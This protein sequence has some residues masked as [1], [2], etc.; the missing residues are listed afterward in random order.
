[1]STVV[2]TRDTLNVREAPDGQAAVIGTRCALERQ[3]S[4]WS[5]RD[6]SGKWGR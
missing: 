1:M 4:S 5:E 6:A 2:E 3:G